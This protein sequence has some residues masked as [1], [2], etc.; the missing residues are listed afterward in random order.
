MLT[1][2]TFWTLSQVMKRGL[3]TLPRNQAPVHA[4][5]SQW[6]S[7]QD[8]IQADYVCAESDVYGVLG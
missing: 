2:T 8:E 1:A 6:I 3:H 7:L 5:A 4:L